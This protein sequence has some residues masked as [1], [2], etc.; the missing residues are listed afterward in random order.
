MGRDSALAQLEA[1]IQNG[2]SGLEQLD[3]VLEHVDS[4]GNVIAPVSGTISSLTAVESSYVAASYPIAVIQ[5]ADQMKI[6]VYV[7]E[8]VV[9]ALKVGDIADVTVENAGVSF[10][11]TIRSVDQSPV[12]QLGLYGVTISVPAEVSGLMV[13]M[14]ADVTFHTDARD[15]VI[16][17]PTQ[18]IQN[19]GDVQYVYVVE[20]DAAVYTEITTGLTGSGVTEVT[21]GLEDGDTLVTVGQSYLTDGSAVRIVNGED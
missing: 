7:S 14:F 10:Q 9:P 3:M 21:S 8:A 18:S 4:Q 15:N 5:G 19:N 11:G 13:G 1:G 12:Q 6:S 2:K 17:I 20:H 16:V